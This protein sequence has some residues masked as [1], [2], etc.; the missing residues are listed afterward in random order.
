M[1]TKTYTPTRRDKLKIFFEKD[2][3]EHNVFT[4]FELCTEIISQVDVSDHNILVLNPEFALVL[5]EE[6]GVDP[7]RITIFADVDPIIETIARRMG[8]NYIDAW[9]YNMKFDVVFANPPYQNGDNESGNF[10]A[11][12]QF[13]ENAEKVGNTVALII[14]QTWSSNVKSPAKNA[15]ASSTVR[16]RVLSKVNL[17]EANFNVKRYFPN[18]GSTFSYV[19]FNHDDY[20]GT[21]RVTDVNGIVFDVNYDEAVFMPTHSVEAPEYTGK[22]NLVNAGKEISGFRGHRDNMQGDGEFLIANTSAKYT[23]GVFL[24]STVKHPY[25]D[26]Q[27]VIFSCSGYSAPFYD[28]GN[29]GLGHHSR[30]FLVDSKSEAE[31]L[32]KFLTSDEL[33]D[34]ANTL[35]DTGSASDLAKLISIG[36]FN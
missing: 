22:F 7:S 10:A 15:Q 3:F 20:S 12:P 30:A 5:I 35:P 13:V 25:Q 24:K 17:I 28:S 4:P 26:K 36:F 31:E 14:P 23:K 34:Y 21:T 33:R 18:V 2:A 29:Y 1:M 16:A 19:I 8:I 9:N 11:W 32:I 27:K 6:F